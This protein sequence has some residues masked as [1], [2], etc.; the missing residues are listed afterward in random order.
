MNEASKDYKLRIKVCNLEQSTPAT[1]GLFSLA[2]T[3]HSAN[4]FE[5]LIGLLL[6]FR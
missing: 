5:F 2:E 3:P 4:D 6:K 1:F